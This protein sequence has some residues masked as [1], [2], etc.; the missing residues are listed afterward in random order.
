[1]SDVGADFVRLWTQ[2][3]PQV[4]RYIGM[5]IPRSADADDVL[6]QTATRLW[7]K[8]QEYDPERPFVSWA[9]RFAYHEVLSWRQRQARS[10]LVFS[11][12]VVAQL[13]ATIND[14]SS[15]LEMRRRALDGCLKKLTERERDLL[16]SRYS[17]HGF[18]Q[19]EAKKS[20]ISAHKLYYVIDKLR[21]QLLKCIDGAMYR[22]GWANG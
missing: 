6:Q 10:R 5:L 20:R 2:C 8:F 14:E 15:L 7:E 4:R 19:Q 1:M 16:L 18:I 12:E 21:F 11:E 3:Q 9:I 22:E 13:D 17:K